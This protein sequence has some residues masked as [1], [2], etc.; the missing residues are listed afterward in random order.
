MAGLG[1]KEAETIPSTTATQAHPQRVGLRLSPPRRAGSFLMRSS[2]LPL[3]LLGSALKLLLFSLQNN[4][5]PQAPRRHLCS[6]CTQQLLALGFNVP[7][8]LPPTAMIP[9][10]NQMF[11]HTFS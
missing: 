5:P 4:L 3:P 11:L 1:A 2:Q 6:F 7:A 9:S 10:H 8:P